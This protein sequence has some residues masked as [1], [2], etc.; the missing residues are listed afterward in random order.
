MLAG[1]C[2]VLDLFPAYCRNAASPPCTRPA[3]TSPLAL[4]V[5]VCNH[6][7]VC[8]FQRL[9]GTGGH[10]KVVL[11]ELSMGAHAALKVVDARDS[12][13]PREVRVVSVTSAC[14]GQTR[15]RVVLLLLLL[16]LL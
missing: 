14:L 5:N 12:S 10:S 7:L 15:H 6:V 13:G 8:T 4:H 11:V 1:G 9:L 2:R 16:L 3:T